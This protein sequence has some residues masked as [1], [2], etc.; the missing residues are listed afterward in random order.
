[1]WGL[2]AFPSSSTAAGAV[3]A[4]RAASRS[5][6]LRNSSRDSFPGVTSKI[7][8]AGLTI[9]QFSL[10]I[11]PAMMAR[12]KDRLAKPGNTIVLKSCHVFWPKRVSIVTLHHSL[13]LD[14]HTYWGSAH[15]C[16][17]RSHEQAT[18]STN[19]F[20]PSSSTYRCVTALRKQT[21]AHQ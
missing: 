6:C 18:G 15:G 14:D 5:F 7:R 16:T 3:P 9:G 17:G 1:M 4:F 19:V 12:V 10:P 8:E 2:M 21:N 20:T 13:S 11:L